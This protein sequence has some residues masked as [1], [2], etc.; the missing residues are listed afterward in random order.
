MAKDNWKHP[1]SLRH[2]AD[3]QIIYEKKEE[4]KKKKNKKEREKKGKKISS[5]FQD[6]N[7]SENE[8]AM[9]T[10]CILS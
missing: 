8:L 5:L 1:V 9:D 2:Y 3:I 4:G 6:N 10:S 7:Y